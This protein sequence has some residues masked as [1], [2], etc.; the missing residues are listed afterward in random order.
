MRFVALITLAAGLSGFASL[1]QAQGTDATSPA[2]DRNAPK[3]VVELYTSQGCSS[4]PAADAL[5][6]Q[7]AQRDDV[8]AVSFA[9]DYWDYLGWKDTLAQTKFTERQKG[10]AKALGDGMVYTPQV[11]VNGAVHVNGSDERKIAAAIEKTNKAIA[12][13][14]VPVRLSTVGD[15]L[16]VE[17]GTAPQGA[18]SKEATIWL[19]VMSPSVEVPITRGEN[20]GKTVTYANV[21]REFMPIGMWNGKPMTVQLQRH[22]ILHAGAERCAVFVQQG[23]GGPIVGAAL[24]NQF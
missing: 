3:A 8:I 11:V 13:S 15:K 7:L 19:A 5:L 4:C 10:Y 1:T 16:V 9:V 22:S 12:A 21:V 23:R 20:K 6:T 2:G 14:H 17:I 24:I 18:G